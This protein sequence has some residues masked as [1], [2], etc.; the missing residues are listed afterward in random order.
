MRRLKEKLNPSFIPPEL[1]CSEDL[2]QNI[3]DTYALRSE[4]RSYTLEKVEPRP[5]RMGKLTIPIKWSGRRVNVFRVKIRKEKFDMDK[6]IDE[7]I[8]PFEKD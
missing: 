1:I 8:K 7:I 6:F 5:E 3:A 4:W 2:A